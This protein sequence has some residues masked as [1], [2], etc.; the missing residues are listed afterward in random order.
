M[1]D[2]T[3][4]IDPDAAHRSWVH[5]FTWHLDIVPPLM[6]A[7][8]EATLPK[9][10]VSRGGSRFDR[11]QITGGGYQDNMQ[12]L[13][14][15]DVVGDGVMVQK[16]AIADARE[17]W[18]WIVQYTRAVDAW[19]APARPAPTLTDNPNPDPNQARGEALVTAGW[20]IDHAAL[21]A[22]VRELE[23]HREA[24]FALIRRL[25]GQY[26]VFNHPRRARPATCTTCG[27]RAV[28]I[29]WIDAGNGSPKPVM[30]GKCRR[31]GEQYRAEERAA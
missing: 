16:G 6:D 7:L 14:M 3:M 31:C 9:I 27:E 20:L 5:A 15:F 17:L 10:P 8:V 4:A 26:A 29:D 28:V 25:R 21:I 19:I 2:I 13:D 12:L 11:L 30:G 24:M 22:E 18:S 23:E 1:T